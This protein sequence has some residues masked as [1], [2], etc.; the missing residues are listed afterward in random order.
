MRIWTQRTNETGQTANEGPNPGDR[1][2]QG[3]SGRRHPSPERGLA[4]AIRIGALLLLGC[5]SLLLV[6]TQC[7]RPVGPMTA[8]VCKVDIT[9]ISPSLLS[10]YETTFG[11]AGEV[12]HSDPIYL[13]GFG[14]DRQATGYNDRL[15]ARGVVIDGADG[16]VAIVS[17]DLVGYFNA[18]IET[19]R[20]LVDPEAGI[21]YIV[22]SST[23]QHE[24]PDT[25]GIWGPDATTSGLDF[26]YLDFVNQSVADCI[27]E[28][29]ANRQLARVKFDTIHSDGLSL[30]TDPE[31]DGFGVADSRVL[32][33]DDLLAPETDGRI[34]DPRLSIMQV[35]EA[36]R[37]FR[38]LAT[39]VNFASHP[40]SLGSN[41]TLITSDFP[42]YARERIEANEGGTAIWVSADL[43]V[44]QGP[45]DIDVE[46]P[47]TGEP[48]IRRTFRWAQVHGEQLGDRVS[49]G[50]SKRRGRWLGRVE[51]AEPERVFVPLDNPYFRFFIAIGV[52][53]S[54][55]FSGGE[56]DASVGFPFPAPFDAIPQALGED[57]GTEVGAF[58]INEAS[59][60]VVP[61][62]LDPQI[63]ERYRRRMRGAR[64]SFIVGLGN[65]EIGYQLPAEK[66]DDSCHACAPFVLGGVPELCPLAPDI[67]CNTV[68]QNNVGQEVD[69]S[70]SAA[71]EPV[72]DA[73]HDR[74][75]HHPHRPRRR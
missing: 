34:I 14:N 64:H 61:S 41:N 52:L 65:D 57:L 18:E 69:P 31:D 47:A 50:I 71:L 25:L 2:R 32:A 30:G 28:A 35:T 1:T 19:I 59:F 10:E 3:P 15:W 38:T 24:G 67:D 72:L 20:S 23:H 36:R 54:G 53:P 26:D 7:P 56:P 70:I 11:V 63:G 8:G 66:W 55:L 51:I 62:E 58:R 33:G 9:P 17:L 43:G 4:G 13:A 29:A 40:E 22:V 21:D 45:L 37:P 16:R 27:D 48:A 46:D 12:N 5:V 42:H 73:L 49:R 6:G 74:N 39:L 68:F 75:P 60:A 44:L